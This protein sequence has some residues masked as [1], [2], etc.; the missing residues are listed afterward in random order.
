MPVFYIRLREIGREQT[1][2]NIALNSTRS[3]LLVTTQKSNCNHQ[4]N[5]SGGSYATNTVNSDRFIMIHTMKYNTK[6]KL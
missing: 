5:I 4:F 3:G 6:L 1:N 2:G